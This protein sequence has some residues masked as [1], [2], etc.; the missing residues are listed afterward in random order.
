[1]FIFFI[2]HLLP[3]SQLFC[4]TTSNMYIYDGVGQFHKTLNFYAFRFS[5]VS[6]IEDC[7]WNCECLS[8]FRPKLWNMMGIAGNVL[9]H[10]IWRHH[11]SHSHI[12]C[13]NLCVSFISNL[14]MSHGNWVTGLEDLVVHTESTGSLFNMLYYDLKGGMQ[15]ML[16]SGCS[17][18]WKVFLLILYFKSFVSWA[19]SLAVQ[20]PTLECKEALLETHPL[21]QAHIPCHLITLNLNSG[22]QWV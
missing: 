2:G 4:T 6:P 9:P 22:M 16:M 18:I 7:L 21:F 3:Q 13:E 5:H 19:M 12:S 1:M 15:Q 17:V 14:L 8:Q 20:T 10:Q 11:H